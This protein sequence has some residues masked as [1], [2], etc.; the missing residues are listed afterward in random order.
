MNRTSTWRMLSIGLSMGLGVVGASGCE[1]VHKADRSDSRQT[2]TTVVSRQQNPYAKTMVRV[3]SLRGVGLKDS[4][5]QE[6]QAFV[7]TMHKMVVSKSWDK[8]S[9]AVQ[10][11][12]VLMT[13]RTTPENHL[14][15]ERY[16]NEVRQV[17]QKPPLSMGPATGHPMMNT[18]SRE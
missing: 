3:Y 12:G 14:S 17:M 11:F 7:D 10:V 15:I 1:S 18:V 16:L 6:I 2:D 4:P 5:P 8:T 13:V 9:S